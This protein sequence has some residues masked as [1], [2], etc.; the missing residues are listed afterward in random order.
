MI[1]ASSVTGKISFAFAASGGNG[2][3]NGGSTTSGQPIQQLEAALDQEIID[4]KAVDDALASQIGA[5]ASGA[6][7]SE[8]NLASQLSAGVCE[9]IC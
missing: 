1:A 6:Q 3:G 8:S 9:G 5:E 4:R 2:N 7:A